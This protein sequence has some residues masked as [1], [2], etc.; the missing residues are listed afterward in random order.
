MN[1]QILRSIFLKLAVTACFLG[2]IVMTAADIIT[3]VLN[4]KANS[5]KQTISDFAIGPYGY[6]EKIGMIMVAVSF[7]FIAINLLIVRNNKELR[8]FKF[9]G[10][11]FVIVALG[12]LMISIFSTNIIGTLI[13]FHGLV[14]Q[15]S[16]I[17]VSVVFYLACLI[18]MRLMINKTS[19]RYFGL[20]CALTCFVGFIVLL[21]LGFS[22]NKN[23]YMGLMERII[24]GFNLVW[25]VLVGPQ[26]IRLARSIQNGIISRR[27]E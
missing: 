6:L 27:Q 25:I 18:L 3:I 14:H 23:E 8:I 9:V 4:H 24:A 21:A 2:P 19:L 22:H 7:L 13:N 10:V 17:A 11:L 26:V 15:V 12:F 16:A 5:L 1:R 20:Y